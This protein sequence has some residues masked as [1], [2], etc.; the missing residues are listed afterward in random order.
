MLGERYGFNVY[1]EEG[2]NYITGGG[3]I[4]FSK[5]VL[6]LV[7][8]SNYCKCPSLTTPDDMFLGIC[9][10]RLQIP[11]THSPFFHQVCFVSSETI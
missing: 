4:V 9:L 6:E 2:Y 8:S 1:N 5:T 3:G 11:V 10:T 7:S